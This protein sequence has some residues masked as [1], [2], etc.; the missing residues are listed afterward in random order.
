MVD[1]ADHIVLRYLREIDRKADRV[2][3]EVNELKTRVGRLETSVAQIH[4]TLAE[5]SLRMDMI[6]GRLDRIERHFTPVDAEA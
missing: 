6:G 4:V 1:E 2:I 3:E 5:H